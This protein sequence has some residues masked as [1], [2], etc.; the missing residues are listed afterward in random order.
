MR[1]PPAPAERWS[2]PVRDILAN[3]TPASEHEQGEGPPNILYT[4]AHHPDLLPS[5]LEF[6]ATLAMRGV[7]PRRDSELLALRAAFNCGCAFEWG[8][9]VEYALAV[10]LGPDEIER[11]A[12]GPSDRDWAPDDRLLLE[13]ADELHA[14]QTLADATF[15][16]LQQRLDPAQ[17]VE[18]CFVVGQYTMLSMV[19]NATGVPIEERLSPLPGQGADSAPSAEGA[20]GMLSG[21]GGDGGTTP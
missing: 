9:H 21:V 14:S 20:R 10:G 16:A 6:S 1:I 12:R 18:L 11:V 17:I 4:V 2:Q 5:M 15:A 19:A 3:L 7:L 8:H 13:A